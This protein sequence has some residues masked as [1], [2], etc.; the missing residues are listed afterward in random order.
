MVDRTGMAD[1]TG[2]F[3]DVL[4]CLVQE[5]LAAHYALK[6][7]GNEKWA[8]LLSDARKA[9]TIRKDAA[10][11][12]TEALASTQRGEPIA[13]ILP[14]LTEEIVDIIPILRAQRDRG[15]STGN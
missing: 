5:Y 13:A 1:K 7:S 12:I 11:V 2:R 8:V 9:P 6:N 15:Q 3:L 14:T 4:S 10:K